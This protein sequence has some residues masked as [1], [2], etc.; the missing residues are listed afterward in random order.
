VKRVLVQGAFDILH[1]GHLRVFE[2]AKAQGDH[3]TVALN[4]NRLIAKYKTRQAVMP[5]SDK[6]ALIKAFRCVDAVVKATAFSPLELL[7]E[8]NIDVYVVADEWVYS[9]AE[10]IHYMEQKGGRVCITPRFTSFSTTAIRKKLLQQSRKDVKNSGSLDKPVRLV[11]IED[12]TERE[13]EQMREFE[14]WR[15]DPNRNAKPSPVL[16]SLLRGERHP[17]IDQQEREFPADMGIAST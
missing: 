1:I 5:W 4:S 2:F 6:K 15:V 9:K 12:L 8:L 14:A 16:T 13:Q 11:G 10:E 3:L 7:R 17:I